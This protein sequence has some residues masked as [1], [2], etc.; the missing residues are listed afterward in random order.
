[1]DEYV[2]SET[3]D[4]NYKNDTDDIY[5]LSWIQLNANIISILLLLHKNTK[6]SDITPQKIY[7]AHKVDVLRPIFYP[8]TR[9]FISSSQHKET[10]LLTPRNILVPKVFL[11]VKTECVIITKFV[12]DNNDKSCDNLL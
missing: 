12:D 8:C 1:M 9:T 10:F 4:D 11:Q 5:R 2:A 3:N 6:N 7:F